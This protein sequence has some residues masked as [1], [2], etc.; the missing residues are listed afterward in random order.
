MADELATCV[1]AKLADVGWIDAVLPSQVTVAQ[2]AC[3]DLGNVS[4][5][6]AS[7]VVSLAARSGVVDDRVECVVA[8]CGPAKVPVVHAMALT[9]DA[10]GVCGVH[11][12][13]R[14]WAKATK[15]CKP[16]SRHHDAVVLQRSVALPKPT[17]W[18]EH[19]LVGFDGN[20]LVKQLLV[21]HGTHAIRWGD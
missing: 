7:A 17:F 10:R 20:K 18:P 8:S 3:A 15:R 21:C 13:L 19:T 6:E 5:G 4:V 16:V 12:G 2:R 9:V 14:W 11:M 1:G